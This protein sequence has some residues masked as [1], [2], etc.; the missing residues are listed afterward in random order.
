SRNQLAPLVAADG[1]QPFALDLLSAGEARDLLARRLGAERVAAEPEAVAEI[2]VRCARL[3]LALAIAAA[4]ATTRPG[5]SLAAQAAQLRDTAGGLD[6]LDGG[7]PA[8]DVRAVFSWSYRALHPPAARL[9][10][11]LG[12]H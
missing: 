9:F 12:L 3:P 8:T 1:A 4:H 6:A 11:L 2:I 7:D 5:S 10:R